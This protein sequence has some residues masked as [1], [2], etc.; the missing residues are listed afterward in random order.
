LRGCF[1]SAAPVLFNLILSLSPD[2]LVLMDIAC[3]TARLPFP[4]AE[5]KRN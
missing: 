4:V 2:I 5:G 1:L 3:E